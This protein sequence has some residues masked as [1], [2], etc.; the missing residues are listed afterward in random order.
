VHVRLAVKGRSLEA[1]VGSAVLAATLPAD[2]AHG[3]VALRAYPSASIEASG[4]SVHK[5]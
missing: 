3:D 4:L 1:K 5:P 2:M